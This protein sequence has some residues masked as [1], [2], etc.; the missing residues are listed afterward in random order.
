[1]TRWRVLVFVLVA[2]CGLTAGVVY[3]LLAGSRGWT[4]A[5]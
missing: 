4:R 1:M 2:W 5:G 3:A